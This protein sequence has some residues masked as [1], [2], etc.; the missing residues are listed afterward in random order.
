[1][2]VVHLRP[3]EQLFKPCHID[4]NREFFWQKCRQVAPLPDRWNS[5]L[6]FFSQSS[7]SMLNRRLCFLSRSLSCSLSLSPF[8]TNT[9]DT[10]FVPPWR[11]VRWQDFSPTLI[12]T[13]TLSLILC[14]S[15]SLIFSFLSSFLSL[16]FSLYFSQYLFFFRI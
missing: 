7:V 13:I 6:T 5:F 11:D 10:L 1:M 2:L 12:L 3:Q 16:S 14:F 9:K 4:P 15:T 8:L